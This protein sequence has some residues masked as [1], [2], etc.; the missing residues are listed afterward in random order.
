M[1]WLSVS[2]KCS[3]IL[4]GQHDK[5]QRLQYGKVISLDYSYSIIELAVKK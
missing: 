3:Q 5:S 2:G 1:C 4:T